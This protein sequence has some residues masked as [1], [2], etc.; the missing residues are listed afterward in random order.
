[1]TEHKSAVRPPMLSRKFTASQIET[2]IIRVYSKA[3]ITESR[4]EAVA[5]RT[6]D[7]RESERERERG[8]GVGGRAANN[9]S[10]SDHLG[11]NFQ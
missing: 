11:W 2:V 8:V 7:A 5:V 3:A 6:N 1:M 10:P 4:F 9:K